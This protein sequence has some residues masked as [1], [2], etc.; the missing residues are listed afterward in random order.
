MARAM[1]LWV[2]VVLALL[3]LPLRAAS[4][5]TSPAEI[6]A[7]PDHFD[8]TVVTLNGTMT[9]PRPRVSRRGNAYY[10]FTL[11]GLTVFSFGAP[12]CPEG[13]RV[14]VEGTFR[15]LKHQ[16]SYTFRNQVDADR[17]VCR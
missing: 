2:S 15:K 10:T 5:E 9:A 12:P 4:L 3:L 7:R 17:V 6:L 16:G 1:R 11:Q 13:A 8:G 14:T